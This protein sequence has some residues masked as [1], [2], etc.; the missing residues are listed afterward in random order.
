MALAVAL[1]MGPGVVSFVVRHRSA[2]DARTA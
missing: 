2:V 1:P